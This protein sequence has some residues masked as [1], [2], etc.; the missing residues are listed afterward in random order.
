MRRH[1][2]FQPV[3]Y[4][5]RI[6]P[7]RASHAKKWNVVVFN[8]LVN[9]SHGNAEQTRQFFD[10]ERLLSGAQLL[11]EGHFANFSGLARMASGA[12]AAKTRSLR[13]RCASLLI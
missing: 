4:L 11:D 12:G 6:K 9:G 7:D 3:R 10:R 5:M 13:S 8:F 2:H 1:F